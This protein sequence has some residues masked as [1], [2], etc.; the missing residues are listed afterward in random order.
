MFTDGWRAYEAAA[1]A[2]NVTHHVVNH[3]VSFINDDGDHT[4]NVEGVHSLLKRIGREQF[5]RLPYI[6]PRG[7]P[8]YID[9]LRSRVNWSLGNLDPFQEMC[10]AIHNW[11]QSPLDDYRHQVQMMQEEE[12]GEEEVEEEEDQEEED[13]LWFE[14]MDGEEEA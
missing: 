6:N 10:K 13:H 2:A 11:S 3:S 9:L 14:Q 7:S 5:H 4:N 8:Y 12:E 1:V